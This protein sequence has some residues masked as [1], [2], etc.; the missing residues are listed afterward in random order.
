MWKTIKKLAASALV[1]YQTRDSQYK[2]TVLV[3]RT[4][5]AAQSCADCTAVARKALS[6]LERGRA[7]GPGREGSRRCAVGPHVHHG[8]PARRRR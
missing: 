4:V 2:Q 7:R 6:P 3:Q 8:T 5:P 1:L